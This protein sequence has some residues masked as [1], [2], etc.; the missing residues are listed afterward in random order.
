MA[1][2]RQKLRKQTHDI[3]PSS[4]VKRQKQSYTGISFRPSVD[5][6][7]SVHSF[8]H[9]RLCHIIAGRPPDEVK[10][11]AHIDKLTAVS[12]FFANE[13]CHHLDDGT[14]PKIRTPHVDAVAMQSFIDFAYAAS[15]DSDINE[16]PGSENL[17]PWTLH[18]WELDMYWVGQVLGCP[19]LCDVAATTTFPKADPI[20]ALQA[21]SAYE[22]TCKE[23]PPENKLYKMVVENMSK[24]W[25]IFV[26]A[27]DK[28]PEHENSLRNLMKRS[29][30]LIEQILQSPNLGCG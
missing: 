8:C 10:F 11:A 1:T 22:Q 16:L 3:T 15:Y 5:D 12:T 21:L 13:L 26:E 17:N 30:S 23:L 4:R 7:V 27:L 9:T 2:T 18:L 14:I 6:Q 25:R 19:K 28:D 24:S 29:P 20:W